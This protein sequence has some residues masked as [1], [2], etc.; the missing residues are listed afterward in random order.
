MDARALISSRRPPEV[1]G[2]QCGV[3]VLEEVFDG[4]DRLLD[5]R[6]DGITKVQGGVAFKR[7]SGWH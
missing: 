1:P 7:W 4:A 3:F 6:Q 2:D 5:F